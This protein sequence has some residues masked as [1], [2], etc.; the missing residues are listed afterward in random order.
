MQTITLLSKIRI[1]TEL[2]I[3]NLQAFNGYEDFI[4]MF[5]GSIALV[6]AACIT[7]VYT[8]IKNRKH[9]ISKQLLQGLKL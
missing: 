3:T 5:E 8:I 6:V 4:L 1:N 7:K 2:V 9:G